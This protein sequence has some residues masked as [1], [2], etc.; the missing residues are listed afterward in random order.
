M[1]KYEALIRAE[2]V[3]AREELRRWRTTVGLE[4][5]PYKVWADLQ[6]SKAEEAKPDPYKVWADLQRSKK[7]KK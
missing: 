7:E 6:R 1:R 3:K 5:D 2:E 4:P